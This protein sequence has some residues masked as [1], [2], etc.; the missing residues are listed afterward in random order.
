MLLDLPFDD[1][2]YSF[3]V[4]VVVDVDDSIRP[5]SVHIMSYIPCEIVFPQNS[6]SW[7]L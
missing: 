2:L 1:S 3:V 4:V 5:F 7:C 6:I